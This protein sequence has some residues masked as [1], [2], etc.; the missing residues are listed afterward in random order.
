MGMQLI[1]TV[2]LGS[3]AS[4]I[5]INNIPDTG[6][7]LLIL[8]SGRADDGPQRTITIILN[9][10]FTGYSYVGLRGTGSAV[11]SLSESFNNAYALVVPG[12]D[13]T[14][15][16]F[17]NFQLY[18]S[19]YTSSVA[20]SISFDGVGENNGTAAQQGITALTSNLTVPITRVRV[21]CNGANFV[22]NSTLS[23]YTIT[24]D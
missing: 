3:S 10:K 6:Q 23:L 14:S 24:A 16:T 13:A 1:E 20:K 5:D 7:D 18:I 15:N 22:A 4:L 9:T 2:T 19:N 17:A 21:Q 8:G 11:E 12:T